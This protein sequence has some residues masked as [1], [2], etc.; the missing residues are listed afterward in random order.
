MAN[1]VLIWLSHLILSLAERSCES[2]FRLDQPYTIFILVT[3]EFGLATHYV[4]QRRL[5]TL[6]A[7]LSSLADSSPEAINRTI[8]EYSAEISP[9]DL[10]AAYGGERRAV[11]DACFSH[12]TVET[13][14]N[15]LNDL[16]ASAGPQAQWAQETLDAM[17]AR[18]PTSLRVALQA[19]RR[20]KSL[21]LADALQMEMGIAT[22]FCVSRFCHLMNC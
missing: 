8:E 14:I 7:A 11:L 21:E 9:D 20:G 13:I 22:A 2:F 19:V 18:S 5:P 10:P 12:N 4:P 17:L 15:D 1:S 3:R 16:V 6:L